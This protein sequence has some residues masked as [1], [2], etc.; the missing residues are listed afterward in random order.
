[1]RGVG[2]LHG[3]QQL[4]AQGVGVEVP[5]GGQPA[6]PAVG[7]AQCL[8]GLL[9]ER[10]VG[11]APLFAFSLGEGREVGHRGAP[12]ISVVG[13]P[14]VWRRAAMEAWSA[15]GVGELVARAAL[16]YDGGAAGV[17]GVLDVGGDEP[18]EFGP[19]GD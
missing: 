10:A 8:D 4:V 15:D 5:A 1:T 13:A 9:D 19:A 7:A 17:L 18:V 16:G 11:G 2:V 6:L 14:L 3:D 12:V